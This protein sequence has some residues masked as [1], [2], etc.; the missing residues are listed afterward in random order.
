MIRSGLRREHLNNNPS[1]KRPL[2]DPNASTHVSNLARTPSFLVFPHEPRLLLVIAAMIITII[3][4]S[5]A[6]SRPNN[7][8]NAF[9]VPYFI[10]NRFYLK[11]HSLLKIIKSRTTY[12]V[13]E[14]IYVFPRSTPN[15]SNKPGKLDPKQ[16]LFHSRRNTTLSLSLS[17]SRSRIDRKSKEY[18]SSSERI[19]SELIPPL[20]EIKRALTTAPYLVYTSIPSDF[21]LGPIPR[22]CRGSAHV[23]DRQGKRIRRRVYPTPA[24]GR[25]K[26]NRQETRPAAITNNDKFPG[27]EHRVTLKPSHTPCSVR[28]LV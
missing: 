4:P 16:V 7:H 8:D 27:T 12:L 20:P 22:I 24:E 13:I 10:K 6:V 28:E 19:R 18:C 5:F 9:T 23:R 17:L 11:I 3:T 2:L 21:S 15:N 1:R 14:S 25:R 26:A